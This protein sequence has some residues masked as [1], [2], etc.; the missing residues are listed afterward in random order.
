MIRNAKALRIVTAILLV[1]FLTSCASENSTNVSSVTNDTF[2]GFFLIPGLVLYGLVALV[3]PIEF[4]I[5]AAVLIGTLATTSIFDTGILYYLRFMPTA[6]LA[7]RTVLFIATNHRRIDTLP[8]LVLTPFGLL[9]I[10]ALISTLYSTD[11][12]VT[13]QRAWSMGFLL[14]GFGVGIP[15]YLAFQP[16][17]IINLLSSIDLVFLILSSASILLLL[18]GNANASVGALDRLTGYFSNPNE[19]GRVGMFA[20]FLSLGLRSEVRGWQRLIVTFASVTAIVSVL[21][22]GSRASLLGI[23]AGIA[24]VVFFTKRSGSTNRMIFAVTVAIL[25][26]ITLT[27]IA[28]PKVISYFDHG[29]DSGRLEIWD[30][31]VAYSMQSPILGFGFSATSNAYLDF[32]RAQGLD[33]TMGGHNSYLVLFSGLG[34]IGVI[35]TALGFTKIISQSITMLRQSSSAFL[36]NGLFAPLI[37]GLTNAI[38]ES[39]LFSF[40]NGVAVFFW[41][42]VVILCMYVQY[43]KLM[44][45]AD[46][47]LPQKHT[48]PKGSLVKTKH[49]KSLQNASNRSENEGT[50]T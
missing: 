33:A 12:L 44:S 1:V 25:V 8:S 31:T 50:E 34:I 40:G 42:N 28:F 49:W 47:K 22:S 30:N 7:G 38:F 29:G 23:V 2:L 39:W 32:V 3:I 36:I 21:L 45:S 27:I 43:P 35:I 46:A 24:A 16:K 19:L 37:G 15:I 11:P 9:F 6:I 5:F 4:L 13:L 20:F 10:Y 18:L 48:Y 41:L 17:R 26:I 14:I